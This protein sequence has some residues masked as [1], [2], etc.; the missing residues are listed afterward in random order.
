MKFIEIDTAAIIPIY[1]QIKEEVQNGLDS[2]K[3]KKGDRLPSIH[4]LAGDYG[5][6]PGTVLKAYRDLIRL[7]IV[8]SVKGKGFFISSTKYVRTL[9]VFCLFDRINAYKEILYDAFMQRIGTHAAVQVFFHHYDVNRFASLI[10]Q[11]AARYNY[12]VIM[13]HFNT[14]VSD[15]LRKIPESRLLVIDK[16]VPDLA[17]SYPSICQDFENDMYRGLIEA[18]L[19]LKKYSYVYFVRSIS[20]FQFIPDGTISGFNRAMTELGMEHKMIS[21]IRN[22]DIRKGEACLVFSDADLI[23]LIKLARMRKWRIGKDLGILSYDDVPMKEVLAGGITTL[24]TDFYAMGNMAA[25][26]ILSGKREKLVNPFR[27]IRRKSL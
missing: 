16:P 1:R 3:L 23:F 26:L 6:A 21:D 20:K 25:E 14:D 2:G 12:Y 4:S 11:H 19:L 15:I 24:S 5:I 22:L 10:R 8:S 7:G 27:L 17:G 13:P 9:N 18:G